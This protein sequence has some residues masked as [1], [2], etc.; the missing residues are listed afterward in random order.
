MDTGYCFQDD[1]FFVLR[2]TLNAGITKCNDS[3]FQ[4]L[5]FV[6]NFL[7]VCSGRFQ[8]KQGLESDELS[9]TGWVD[10]LQSALGDTNLSVFIVG[11][12]K[13]FR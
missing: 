6:V 10:S 5:V 8:L 4:F 9:L 3:C 1:H 13:Y 12:H 2:T 7:H 11:L